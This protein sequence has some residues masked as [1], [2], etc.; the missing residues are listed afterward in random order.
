MVLEAAL[1]NVVSH[2]QVAPGLLL[3]LVESKPVR[4]I[5]RRSSGMLWETIL[6]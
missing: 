6:P 1:S 4:S 3:L 5:S 2:A